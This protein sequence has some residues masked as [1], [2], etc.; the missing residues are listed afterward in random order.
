MRVSVL[1]RAKKLLTAALA[2]QKIRAGLPD[3]AGA[4]A[5]PARPG[6]QPQMPS[7]ENAHFGTIFIITCHYY[8]YDDYKWSS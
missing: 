5:A 3:I 8:V 4:K 1:T 6:A 7:L 2:A